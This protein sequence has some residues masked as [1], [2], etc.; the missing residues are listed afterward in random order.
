LASDLDTGALIERLR[1]ALS[2]LADAARG[3]S[4]LSIVELIQTPEQKAILDRLTGLMS[5]LEGHADV[6]MDQVGPEVVPS[7]ETIRSRFDQRR[8]DAGPLGKIF[9]RLIGMEMKMKQYAEGAQF[10]RAVINE[11]GMAGLNIVWTSS[12]LLPSGEEIRNPNL[13]LERTSGHPAVSA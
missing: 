10:V 5:L 7:V 3:K 8:R 12:D 4:G 9:R 2:G 1:S 11:V 6:I 13:W